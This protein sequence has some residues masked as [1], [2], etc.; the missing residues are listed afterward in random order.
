MEVFMRY[1]HGMVFIFMFSLVFSS[2]SVLGST[3]PAMT[4]GS[5]N[6]VASRLTAFITK[7]PAYLKQFGGYIAS[8]AG[9]K[10]VASAYGLATGIT[11]AHHL[12]HALTAKL[13]YGSP[14]NIVL[15]TPDRTAKPYAQMGGIKVAGFNP[16]AGDSCFSPSAQATVNKW[17]AATIA[18]PLCGALSSLGAYLLLK[19][20]CN[21]LSITKAV[22]LCGI[23]RNTLGTQGELSRAWTAAHIQNTID[24]KKEN[25]V[26][27]SKLKGLQEAQAKA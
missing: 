22:A 5:Q 26:L 19:K 25:E 9:L 20:Y 18:G 11:A 1:S 13:L 2:M 8:R 12:G 7:T 4:A 24:V 3:A 14:I 6:S 16:V 21:H 10:D 15:G 17:R 23:L 27:K